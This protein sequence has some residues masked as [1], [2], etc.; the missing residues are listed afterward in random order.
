[1]LF[2]KDNQSGKWIIVGFPVERL[3]SPE[4]VAIL[5]ARRQQFGDCPVEVLVEVLANNRNEEIAT[6]AAVHPDCPSEAR[7]AWLYKNLERRLELPRGRAT[8]RSVKALFQ[9]KRRTHEALS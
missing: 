9:T 2:A 1:M 6:W 5:Y 3:L 7:L 4:S 8:F